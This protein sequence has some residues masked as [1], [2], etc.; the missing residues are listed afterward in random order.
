MAV[1]ALDIGGTNTRSALFL[2]PGH[3]IMATRTSNQQLGHPLT[4]DALGDYIERQLTGARRAGFTVTAI[5]LAV[6]AV[7][8]AASGFIYVGENVGWAQLPLGQKLIERF[9]L[10]IYIDTDA[11]C[12]ALAEARLGAG[13]DWA[14]FLYVTIGTGIGHALVMQRSVW[15]GAH[16]AA[17]VFGHFVMVPDGVPCYCGNRGCLCLYASGDGLARMGRLHR[18]EAE[19]VTAREIVRAAGQGESWAVPLVDQA[20]D[21]LAVALSHVYNLLDIEG[22]IFD[23]GAVSNAYPD[24]MELTRR[25]E[26]HVYPSMRPITLR[27]SQLN[28]SSVIQGAAQLAFDAQT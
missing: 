21:K 11:H 1:L 28:S 13:S 8:D 2:R 22:V 19:G 12:G 5:G 4:V 14:S 9:G 16:G 24:L 10:P 23:G 6:A 15:R 20:L 25:L 18:P 3:D 7:V 26:V 17:N 27:R